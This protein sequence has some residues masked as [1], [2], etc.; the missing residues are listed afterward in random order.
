M[1]EVLLLIFILNIIIGWKFTKIYPITL[2]IITSW[3]YFW[4]LISSLS[5]TGLKTPSPETYFIYT[6]MLFSLT[7]GSF[8]YSKLNKKK[9]KNQVNSLYPIKIPIKINQRIN[10]LI[11][12]LISIATP[13][14]CYF[15]FKSI[16]IILTSS[17]LEFFRG[18]VFGSAGA[19]S[20][21]FGPGWVEFLFNTIIL[22]SI[23]IGLFVG[24][25]IFILNGEKKLLVLSSIL[26]I[27]S[28]IM[29]L[30]RFNIYLVLVIILIAFFL[31][32]YKIK[33]IVIILII[34]IT[35]IVMIGATRGFE[36]ISDQ[37]KIF[38]IDYHTLGFSLF[39]DELTSP[40]SSLNSK[41]KFGFSSLGII[42]NSFFILA[43][44]LGLTERLGAVADVD[45][46]TFRNLSGAESEPKFYNAFGTIIYSLY[47]DGGIFFVISVPFIFGFLLNKHTNLAFNRSSVKYGSL[48][49]LYLY[50]GI[51]G[52][53]QP[54][55]MTF[56][57]YQI[58]G[59]I[60]LFAAV[61]DGR[62]YSR[63]L[64]PKRI[65]SI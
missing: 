20:I 28:G 54:L 12:F 38:I 65:E 32:K 58:I 51:F 63:K 9:Q 33:N 18:A 55:L 27:A 49:F 56:I 39:D 6:L 22:V 21:I 26:M 60:L 29:M 24:A 61:G 53:F 34:F 46:N 11:Y 44:K 31:K 36:S 40:E 5:L 30:G 13:V 37:V 19:D 42:E 10:L 16:S 48:V 41:D 35:P 3:W 14:V 4:L 23:H 8:T 57:W 47:Y 2:L 50:L 59:I 17:D 62:S 43:R 45:L 64:G 25:S 7:A 15:L 52:I 1:T